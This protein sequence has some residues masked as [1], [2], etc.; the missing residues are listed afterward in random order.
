MLSRLANRTKTISRLFS[1]S[2]NTT[3]T[4]QTSQ[5]QHYSTHPNS[6]FYSNT[7]TDTD[8]PNKSAINTPQN[9]KLFLH[10]TGHWDQ[11]C[12]INKRLHVTHVVR[13]AIEALP[14]RKECLKFLR[15]LGSI[16]DQS[17]LSDASS[18]LFRLSRQL[19]LKFLWNDFLFFKTLHLSLFRHYLQILLFRSSHL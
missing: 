9:Q 16:K 1:T 2:S 14:N 13:M 12:L 7:N 4:S 18:S 8:N 5:H 11:L 10:L 19:F 17:V 15:L 3:Q 6:S